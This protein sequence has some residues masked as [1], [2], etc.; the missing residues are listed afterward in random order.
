M[1]CNAIQRTIYSCHHHRRRHHT[2]ESSEER[3]TFSVSIFV[4]FEARSKWRTRRG[5]RTFERPVLDGGTVRP[6]LSC[7]GP[8]GG[9][10]A[11]KRCDNNTRVTTVDSTVV[12]SSLPRLR[13]NCAD[14]DPGYLTTIQ[15]GMR[16]SRQ[17]ASCELT[18][19]GYIWF[20]YYRM[21][22]LTFT[23]YRTCPVQLS[24]GILPIVEGGRKTPI[25][26]HKICGGPCGFFGFSHIHVSSPW[27]GP[28]QG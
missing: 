21:H 5:A 24:L 27:R 8:R 7:H 10:S 28:C 16:D 3:P 15:P 4:H 9:L 23:K 12:P 14:P 17:P 25:A 20:P 6:S 26:N 11:M 13:D 2:R 1:Q 22:G 19:T 18:N